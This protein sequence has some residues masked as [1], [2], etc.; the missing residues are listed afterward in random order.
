M[1]VTD[2]FAAVVSNEVDDE[3]VLVPRIAASKVAGECFVCILWLLFNTSSWAVLQCLGLL[4]P[5]NRN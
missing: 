1:P 5:E 3:R 4:R 2:P